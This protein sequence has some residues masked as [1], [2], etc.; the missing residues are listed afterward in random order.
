MVADAPTMPM[1]ALSRRIRCAV[2]AAPE[3][4]RAAVLHALQAAVE[5]AGPDDSIYVYF[6]GHGISA[7]Q[8]VAGTNESTF[9]PRTHR[10]RG[11]PR[12]QCLGR[13][14][15]GCWG[16]ASCR[17]ILILLDCCEGAAFAEH[18]PAMFRKLRRGDFRILLSSV[19]AD[20]RSWER[21]DGAGTLFTNALVDVLNAKVVVG[22][23]PGALYFSRMGH[24]DRQAR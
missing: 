11:W 14:S 17:G 2:F 5:R 1:A 9:A 6:A 19:R 12:Q 13:T 3:A 23:T 8:R 10:T 18:A 24:R 4:T 20:Q 16:E 7:G 21:V 22:S 15:R